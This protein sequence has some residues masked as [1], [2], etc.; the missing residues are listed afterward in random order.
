MGDNRRHTQRFLDTLRLKE[1]ER[2]HGA[3]T[4]T[5]ETDE[6]PTT[7]WAKFYKDTKD[8]EGLE[9]ELVAVYVVGSRYE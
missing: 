8:K 4:F 2:A 7:Q 1:L 5:L 6:D 9:L 3:F